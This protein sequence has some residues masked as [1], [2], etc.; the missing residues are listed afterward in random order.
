MKKLT[1]IIA[2]LLTSLA[3]ICVANAAKEG[4]YIGGGLGGSTIDA[5]VSNAWETN[6]N[7]VSGLGGRVFAGYNFNKNFGLE[8]NY[9]KYAN[10]KTTNNFGT[11]LTK[12]LDVVTLVGKVYLPLGDTFNLYG[13]AGAAEKFETNKSRNILG[14]KSDTSHRVL[15][16]TYGVGANLDITNHVTTSVEYSRIQGHNTTSSPNSDM[17]T[18][19]LAYNFG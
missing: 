17:I 18:V 19:N 4:T 9:A 6:K 2:T 7:T 15:R 1:T 8:G 13:L 16:P 5:R 3:T 12:E 14:M 10:Q 11:T